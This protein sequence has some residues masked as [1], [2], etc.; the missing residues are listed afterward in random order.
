M[1]TGSRGD[2]ESEEPRR[3]EHKVMC[4]DAL[5]MNKGVHMHRFGKVQRGANRKGKEDSSE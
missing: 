5:F 3:A 1:A 4:R 2:A